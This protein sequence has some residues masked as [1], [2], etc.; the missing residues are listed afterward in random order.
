[1]SLR[2]GRD[3]VERRNILPLPG[4]EGL[5][6]PV[7]SRY[8]DCTVSVYETI[9]REQLNCKNNQVMGETGRLRVHQTSTLDFSFL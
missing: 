8:T 7:A 2:A 3:D 4:L 5:T 9:Q 6:L 1:V